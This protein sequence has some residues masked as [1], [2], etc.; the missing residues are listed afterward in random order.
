[1]ER[2]VTPLLDG[3]VDLPVQIAHGGGAHPG[4]PEGFGDV[5]DPPDGDAGQVHF[6][7]GLFDGALP[8]AVTLDDRRLEGELPK[9]GNLE[10]DLAGLGV[11][12]AAVMAGAGIE[13]LWR[14]LIA[15]GL[16]D[17]VGLGVEQRVQRV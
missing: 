12:L 17:G 6:H 15:P 9:L 8:A 14:P 4:S 3:T 10:T 2:S 11:K 16:A 1:M 7:Q 5:F 13:P